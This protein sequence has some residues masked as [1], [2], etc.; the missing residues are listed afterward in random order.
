MNSTDSWSV[1][2][3]VLVSLG[4]GGL[5]VLALSSWLGK[6]WASR[7]LANEGAQYARDLELIKQRL[8]AQ[9]HFQRT[10][11]DQEFEIYQQLWS[12]AYQ[13]RVAAQNL[14]PWHLQNNLSREERE[15]I[16]MNFTDELM[17]FDD[18]LQGCRPFFNPE[19]YSHASELIEACSAEKIRFATRSNDG[20]PMEQMATRSGS[21]IGL[22]SAEMKLCE[23]IRARLYGNDAHPTTLTRKFSSNDLPYN[24]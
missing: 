18:F 12:R 15:S 8:E 3:S 24:G 17:K 23:A 22:L 20:D 7:I 14:E 4:G 1:A 11:F 2:A 9:L 5:I 13:T 10:L 19:I 6:V 16:Y 21:M